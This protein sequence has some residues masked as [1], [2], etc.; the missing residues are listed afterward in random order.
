MAKGPLVIHRRGRGAGNLVHY[1][2]QDTLTAINDTQRQD[3][4]KALI[5]KGVSD[6]GDEELLRDDNYKR[7]FPWTRKMLNNLLILNNTLM[8]ARFH[9]EIV[10]QPTTASE[11]PP[12]LTPAQQQQVQ[13]QKQVYDAYVAVSRI[14]ASQVAPPS[15]QK[16]TA[17]ASS[18]SD[19]IHR[20]SARNDS[21]IH[22][23]S[24]GN[25][26]PG[27]VEPPLAYDNPSTPGATTNPSEQAGPAIDSHYG[28]ADYQALTEYS[29]NM[30]SF[31]EFLP[32]WNENNDEF[33]MDRDSDSYWGQAPI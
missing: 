1:P 22:L 13:A 33:V 27:R 30:E 5:C 4:N 15:T 11:L 20:S 10:D 29:N 26:F 32:F 19:L 25:S 7:L 24:H 18:Q 28:Q 12:N 16:A 9:M 6:D 8:G 31:S 17:S 3:Y 23:Q 14:A 21:T 2:P